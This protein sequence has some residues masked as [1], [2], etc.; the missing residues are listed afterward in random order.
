M[1]LSLS[2]C[3]NAHKHTD[4]YAIAEEARELGFEFIEISHGTSVALLPGLMRAYDTGV[5]RVSSVHNFCPS[6]VEAFMDAPDLYEFTSTRP[7]EAER[8]ITLTQQSIQTAVRFG[9]NRVVVHLGSVP[10]KKH[11]VQLEKLVLQG[12]LY[13]RQYTEAKLALVKERQ[14]HSSA[15]MDR[16]RRA[17]EQILPVAEQNGVALGIE[18]RSYH[19]QVPDPRE[20]ELLLTEYKDCPWIGFWHD[21]GHVQRQA[22][23]SLVDHP[24][25]LRLIAPRL[26]GCHV[27]D[28]DWPAKDHRVPLSTGGVAFDQLMPLVPANIPLVWELSQSQK[29]STISE[30]LTVWKHR[31]IN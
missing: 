3:W 31:Y 12:E 9:A 23:L 14:H 26:L 8:A 6:P 18:T 15:A 19:E 20:L 21:F 1:I 27:H 29:R 13:S 28:V 10:I 30:A 22:N 24:Q 2:T 16:V 4:G 5:I 25:Q 7:G 11:T 17:L